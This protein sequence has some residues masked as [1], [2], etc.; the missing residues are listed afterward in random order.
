M[1]SAIIP[2]TAAGVRKKRGSSSEETVEAVGGLR[3]GTKEVFWQGKDSTSPQKMRSRAS[4]V[5]NTWISG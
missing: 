3:G 5:S 1:D 2:G 4:N